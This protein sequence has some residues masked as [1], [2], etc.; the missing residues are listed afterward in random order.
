VL[1]Q[2]TAG[3]DGTSGVRGIASSIGGVTSGVYGK[4]ASREDGAAGVHGVAT[5]T[6]GQVYGVYGESASS[7]PHAAGVM[8]VDKDLTG[9]SGVGVRGEIN[10]GR[11]GVMGYAKTEGNGVW[12]ET[13]DK[14]PI[15]AG[16]YGRT[17]PPDSF[18]PGVWGES[19]SPWAPG[20][21]GESRAATEA[22]IGVQ[23]LAAS[24]AGIGV[25]G[26]AAAASGPTTGVLGKV[27]SDSG[28]GVEGQSASTQGASIGVRGTAASPD[29]Y[30]VIGENAALSGTAVGVLAS[31][32]SGAG[33]ALHVVTTY[34]TA[35]GIFVERGKGYFAGDVQ[36]AGG[37]GPHADVAENYHA[38]GVE[39]GDV[40]VIAEDGKLIRCAT[41]SDTRVAGIVSTS[42][43]MSV[44]RMEAGPDAAPLAL[45]GI[46]P[47]K[48]DATKSPIKPGD[49]LVSCSTPGHA[50]KCTS[51]RPAAGTVI[52]KALEG[53]EK[54]TG[55]IQVLVT[56]R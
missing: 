28:T 1:G 56:L 19:M 45:V 22:G 55:V 21:R 43:T 9:S 37:H 29:G 31:T 41:E 18:A 24:T 47:C 27:L 12:G 34:G 50:M 48:V 23:G 5:A 51:R 46:V 39:A 13:L 36:F 53:L 14:R 38:R 52:G 44:G 8:G 11:A 20:V 49:L 6:T 33:H 32:A 4:S 15:S 30:G 2:T 10:S 25:Q 3:E 16:V 7:N 35:Y 54:G 40:V 17:S 26:Q 42:P